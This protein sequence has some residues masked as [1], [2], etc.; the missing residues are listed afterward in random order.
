MARFYLAGPAAGLAERNYLRRIAQQL[1]QDGHAVSH[2]APAADSDAVT[3]VR[4]ADAVVALLDGAIVDA[5]AAAAAAHAHAIGKPVL[6]LHG[7]APLPPLVAACLTRR[8]RI[9]NGADLEEALGLFYEEVRPFAGRLVR[10]QI[11]RLVR[12]AGHEVHFRELASDDRPGFLKRKVAEEAAE[13]ERASPGAEKEEIADVLE[14]LEALIRARGYDRDALRQV[15]QAKLKRRGGFERCFVV[16]ATGPA[17]PPTAG[18]AATRPTEPQ[19]VPVPEVAGDEPD[20]DWVADDDG[21]LDD[22][23]DTIDVALERR[24]PG[25]GEV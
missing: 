7:D 23:L 8:A 4:E 16:E 1:E 6:G 25:V 2:A 18:A 14:A 10:D 20:V 22:S 15:K 13:L 12:E 3:E 19:P 11:P 9:E 5:S 17:G 24:R 21:P